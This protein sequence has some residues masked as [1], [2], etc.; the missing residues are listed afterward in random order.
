MDNVVVFYIDCKMLQIYEAACLTGVCVHRRFVNSE[1]AVLSRVL[2][3]YEVSVHESSKLRLIWK[4]D[5]PYTASLL[6]RRII[7]HILGIDKFVK[8]P[9]DPIRYPYISSSPIEIC[10]KVCLISSLARSIM[11]QFPR[12]ELHNIAR[13]IHYMFK[14][15]GLNY[16]VRQASEG[17]LLYENVIKSWS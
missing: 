17:R 9:I 15:L 1:I 8:V 7:R 12:M 14:I 4:C 11:R 5:L 2:E 10:R 3:F 13:L 16:D 6:S